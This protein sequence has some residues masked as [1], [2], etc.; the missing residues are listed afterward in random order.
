MGVARLRRC[1]KIARSGFGGRPASQDESSSALP[2][3]LSEE[4]G[5]DFVHSIAHHPLPSPN[6]APLDRG[7]FLY[8]AR[9][10]V[11][12]EGSGEV[13][14]ARRG[15]IP[16][17]SSPGPGTWRPAGSWLSLASTATR[18]ARTRPSRFARGLEACC[19][20]RRAEAHAPPVTISCAKPPAKG[21]PITR[22]RPKIDRRSPLAGAA[23]PRSRG[24]ICLRSVRTRA[25]RG[26]ATS[27]VPT[28]P[29]GRIQP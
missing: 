21:V 28:T 16:N 12:F 10:R 13:I 7:G 11:R 15:A 3:S 29:P 4:V 27:A 19:P 23:V 25:A 9:R 26:R 22:E 20:G 1:A 14:P 6:C 2:Y 17:R 5:H 18:S 8:D 24:A